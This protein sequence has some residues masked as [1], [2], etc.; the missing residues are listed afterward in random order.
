M[1]TRKSVDIEPEYRGIAVQ[2][3]SEARDFSLFQIVHNVSG[4]H[5]SYYSAGTRIS[6]LEDKTFG[7]RI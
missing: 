7:T 6:F 3:S 5:P 2:S 4:F 1:S